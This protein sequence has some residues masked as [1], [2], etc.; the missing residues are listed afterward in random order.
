MTPRPH[1]TCASR[2]RPHRRWLLPLLALPLHCAAAA[3]W[4]ASAGVTS[5]YVQRGLSQTRGKPALQASAVYAGESG[6]YAGL[7]TSTIDTGQPAY[8]LDGADVEL[9]LIAGYNH[10]TARGVEMDLQLMRY[11]Y[12]G[13]DDIVDYVHTEIAASVTYQGRLRATV[14]YSPDFSGIS[15]AGVAYRTAATTAE[16]SFQQ[17]LTPHLSIGLAVGHRAIDA[18]LGRDYDYGSVG[19]GIGLGRF[20]I[21]I[22]QHWTDRNARYQF[23]SDLA[24]ARTTL[25]VLFDLRSAHA[26][27]D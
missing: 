14:D 2:Q 1:G 13:A 7:W 3:G 25:T 8:G 20:S 12:P 23:G 4:N 26:R 18:D 24:G 9:D 27:N 5:D 6:W 11:T 10:L 19:L 17:P 15:H 21:L 16:L 22:A